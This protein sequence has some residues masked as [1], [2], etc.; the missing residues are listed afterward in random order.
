MGAWRRFRAAAYDRMNARFEATHGAELRARLLE[1]A[2][3][4]VLEIG[5][6]TGANLPHYPAAIDELVLTEPNEAM[7]ER[8][9]RRGATAA[10]PATLVQASAQE[11][12]FPDE[13]FDTVVSTVVLCSV[14]DQAAALREVRRVLRPGGK[15]LFVEHVRSDDPR[16]AKWQ[17]RLDPLW[18]R[19]ADGCHPNR[20]T[21]AALEDAGFAVE[22]DEEGELPMMPA[23]VRPY[24]L[25][26]ATPAR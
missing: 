15:L 16:V 2:S 6:G 21:K 25:G 24:V 9:R 11:L 23:I 8:A 10:R 17:D 19:L 4:R 26:R 3:G 5:A 7:L 18:R 20:T 13:S 1:G 22:L 14:P 12:P